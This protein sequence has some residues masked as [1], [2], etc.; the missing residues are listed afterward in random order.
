MTI[1]F[2]QGR[3]WE[4]EAQALSLELCANGRMDTSPLHTV[5]ADRW[6]VFVSDYRQRG[7]NGALPPGT[8]WIW[9][10]STPWLVGLVS[11]ETPQ[12]AARL[13][14]IEGALLNLAKVWVQEGLHS[15]A[16][17]PLG[18]AEDRVAI[19]A[20]LRD[21]FDNSGLAITVYDENIR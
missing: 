1:T 13:R 7:R 21:M 4:A 17:G 9:R 12:G 10:E 20:M 8:V 5:L 3:L 18:E 19:E 11:R 2:A 16:L 14:H 15:V 6:P